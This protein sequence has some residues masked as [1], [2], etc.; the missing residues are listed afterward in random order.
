MALIK[1]RTPAPATSRPRVGVRPAAGAAPRFQYN[2]RTPEQVRE[3]AQRAIGGKDSFFSSEVQFFTPRV[4]DNNVRILPPPVDADWGH[5]GL[6]LC[7][8]YGIGSD[9][10]AYLCASKMKGE[11]CPLCEERDKATSA[12]E[13][14]LADALRPNYRVAVYVI[15]RAQEAKGPLLWSIAAGLDKD[16]TKLCI[17]PAN[18]EVLNVDDPND[19]YDLNFTREGEGMKTKYKGI[20]FSR[21][22]SPL[23]DDPE[24]AEAWLAHAAEHRIDTCLQYFDYDYVSKVF[25]GQAPPEKEEAPAAPARTARVAPRGAKPAAEAP[26]PAPRTRIQPRAAVKAAAPAP[27]PEQ[28]DLPTWE[29]L[30]ALDEDGLAQLGEEAEL[31]FPDDG[32]NS[33]EELRDFV[34]EALGIAP[35]APAPAPAAAAGAKGSWRDR[36]SKLQGKK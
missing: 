20:Q 31:V 9:Q 1:P 30:E 16:I 2:A 23:S 26:A 32:F 10:S 35:P 36:L 28:A 19:G 6:N 24:A 7:V 27:E 14:E 13:E 17:D 4:G 29:E 12:G 34:A 5:Y 8:H 33:L 25:E 11:P 18:G 22:S 15:D 3:R 21:K